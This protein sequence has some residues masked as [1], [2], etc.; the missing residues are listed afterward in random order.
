MSPRLQI[1]ASEPPRLLD[2]ASESS[3]SSD[4]SDSELSVF[5]DMSSPQKCPPSV[6]PPSKRRPIQGIPA[7]RHDFRMV[8]PRTIRFRSKSLECSIS[9]KCQP[10]LARCQSQCSL[11]DIDKY[12][13]RRVEN[14]IQK[15]DELFDLMETPDARSARQDQ[16]RAELLDS[17]MFESDGISDFGI[18]K[19]CGL[20][21]SILECGN[22]NDEKHEMVA[23]LRRY[24][25]IVGAATKNSFQS[26]RG[27]PK[28]DGN[29]IS[30][31][32][33]EYHRYLDYV[34]QQLDVAQQIMTIF[35]KDTKKLVNS[36]ATLQLYS[37]HEKIFN[38]NLFLFEHL[39]HL[40]SQHTFNPLAIYY[41]DKNQDVSHI[42][43]SLDTLK[44]KVPLVMNALFNTEPL[45][46]QLREISQLEVHH[47]TQTM[48]NL[49]RELSRI[50]IE[51]VRIPQT[52][53]ENKLN[54]FSWINAQC[55]YHDTVDLMRIYPTPPSR[56]KELLGNLFKTQFF[57]DVVIAIPS[58]SIDV[59]MKAFYH[60]QVVTEVTEAIKTH[61]VISNPRYQ[62]SIL[63][64]ALQL[65]L[66][67][68]TLGK[69]E[70]VQ[71]LIQPALIGITFACLEE[72]ICVSLVKEDEFIS[73]STHPQPSPILKENEIRKEAN[74][75]NL[76]FSMIVDN[77]TNGL[78]IAF[79]SQ[80]NPNCYDRAPFGFLPA[81]PQGSSTLWKFVL[82]TVINPNFNVLSRLL[83][84]QTS[85]SSKTNLGRVEQ[86]GL[87]AVER[88]EVNTEALV[89]PSRKPWEK[90]P[91]P[92]W[93]C[94][95]KNKISL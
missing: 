34:K 54:N 28:Y 27:G 40:I 62:N 25:L 95:I 9:K 89:V 56:V 39:L 66:L 85:M 18:R 53:R 70:D 83:R 12:A 30:L 10:T 60:H 81:R 41:A 24:Q 69:N 37:T 36:C 14:T 33:N 15:Y 80:L 93:S 77:D 71:L 94:K 32:M 61:A 26:F 59:K 17:R 35:L 6:S 44:M 55:R 42:R 90:R 19:K 87:N 57:A 78:S 29:V 38:V 11:N 31:V 72:K 45:K 13:R 67:Y 4:S 68:S 73:S 5:L 65:N 50:A 52:V 21:T 8:P 75:E 63:D 3:D 79:H 43:K 20:I 91:R 48:L 92:V 1:S 22:T 58:K 16:I 74:A 46:R 84:Q 7:R 82:D 64:S 47:D 86:P 23:A 51:R 2:N 49:A 76:K 88:E